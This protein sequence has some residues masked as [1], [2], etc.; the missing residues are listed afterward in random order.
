MDI[1]KQ[2]H[3]CLTHDR[4]SHLFKRKPIFHNLKYETAFLEHVLEIGICSHREM[5][6]ILANDRHGA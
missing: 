6:D 1:C 2:T 3:G 4:D 5:M